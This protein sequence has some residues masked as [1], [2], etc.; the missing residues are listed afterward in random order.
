MSVMAA[1]RQQGWPCMHSCAP[2]GCACGCKSCLLQPAVS[3][4]C[5]PCLLSSQL[6]VCVLLWLPDCGSAIT[7]HAWKAGLE[8]QSSVTPAS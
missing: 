5:L 3:F 2:P 8:G 7:L 4:R 1:G 6:H